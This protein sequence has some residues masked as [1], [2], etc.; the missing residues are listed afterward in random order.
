[1]RI[2]KNQPRPAKYLTVESSFHFL[3]TRRLKTGIFRKA[4]A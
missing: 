1:M 3:L 2:S 4:F